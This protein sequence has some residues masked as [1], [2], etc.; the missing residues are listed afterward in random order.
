MKAFP[1]CLLRL[2]LTFG[3]GE[4]GAPVSNHDEKQKKEQLARTFQFEEGLYLFIIFTFAPSS[5]GGG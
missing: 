4:G 1:N 2:L 5:M 3:G